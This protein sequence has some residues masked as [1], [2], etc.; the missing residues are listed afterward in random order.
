MQLLFL[1]I[2]GCLVSS[3]VALAL[4]YLLR[5]ACDQRYKLYE[6]FLTIPVGK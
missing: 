5:M 2:E 6:T 3:C 4:M 1:L